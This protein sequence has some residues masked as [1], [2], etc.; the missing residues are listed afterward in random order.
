MTQRGR[1]TADQVVAERRLSLVPG[2]KAEPPAELSEFQA[3]VWRQVVGSKPAEWFG[4]DTERLLIAYC[5]HA[6]TAAILDQQVDA[7]NPEWMADEAGLRRY[8]TLTEMRERETRAMVSLATKMRLTQQSRYKS[9]T[10]ERMNAREKEVH[11]WQS[12]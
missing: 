1:K 4:G 12:G 5:R 3:E 10:A 7:F 6:S 9:E 11:P 2:R 8:K